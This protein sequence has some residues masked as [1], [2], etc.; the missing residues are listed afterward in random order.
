MI[1][2]IHGRVN[3]Q[4]YEKN[5]RKKREQRIGFLQKKKKKSSCLFIQ[6]CQ[7]FVGIGN[8]IYY[9]VNSKRQLYLMNIKLHIVVSLLHEPFHW[10]IKLL[11]KN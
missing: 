10:Y 2:A 8:K 4:L 11:D 3:T 1:S 6:L 7:T 5:S 9:A